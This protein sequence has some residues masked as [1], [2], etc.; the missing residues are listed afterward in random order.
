MES[1]K[2]YTLCLDHK[3]ITKKINSNIMNSR[4]L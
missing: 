1:D 3:E 4:K 2:L